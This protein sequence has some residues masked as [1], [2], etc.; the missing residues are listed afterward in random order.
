MNLKTPIADDL[1]DISI[2][3]ELLARNPTPPTISIKAY[4]SQLRV[5]AMDCMVVELANE[6]LTKAN[7]QTSTPTRRL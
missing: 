1:I 3:L 4:A 7:E 6:R 5:R 2:Q